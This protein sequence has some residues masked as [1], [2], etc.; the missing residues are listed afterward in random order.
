MTRFRSHTVGL[1]AAL[2]ALAAAAGCSKKGPECES[3][4]KIINPAA[5]KMKAANSGK[6]EKA[7]EH[8]K[9]MTETA[10][11]SEG[12]AADLAKLQL[13]LPELQKLSTEY[14]AMAKSVAGAAR[15][16]ASALKSTEDASKQSEKANKDLE[17]AATKHGA[18]CG[19]VKDAKDQDACRRFQDAMGKL[20]SDGTKTAEVEKVAVE[21]EKI[22]WK[23][24]DVKASSKGVVAAI[25]ANNKVVI[26]VKAAQTKAEG[27]QKRIEDAESKESKVID[28]INKLCQG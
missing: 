6:A 3:V 10:K 25:R 11:A 26:D 9:A 21:L 22:E 5:E 28:G 14:Q 4:I 7:E 15:D 16:M 23:G 19:G 17:A 24:D 8:I 20:P 12:A 13:S 2:V 27:A 18:A 1:V